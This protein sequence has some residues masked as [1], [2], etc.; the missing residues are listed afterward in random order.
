MNKILYFSLT[1]A[2]LALFSACEKDKF[3][4]DVENESVKKLP[5]NIYQ[6][7]DIAQTF[8]Y[9]DL[10]RLIRV[11]RPSIGNTWYEFSYNEANAPI[12]ILSAFGTDTLVYRGNQVFIFRPNLNPPY[13]NDT[14]IVTLNATGEIEQ[15][16]YNGW[17]YAAP[18]FMN[19][20]YNSNGN[21]S[22]IT[23]LPSSSGRP[24]TTNFQYSTVPSIFRHVNTPDWFF[25]LYSDL[26]FSNYNF[27]F[28]CNKKGYMFSSTYQI[29]NGE[30][31]NTSYYYTYEV[32]SDGLGY[33][34]KIN[35]RS[36]DGEMMYPKN[37][38][39]IFAK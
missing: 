38:Q 18:Y 6:N 11:N 14:T 34:W 39:Y 31:V 20:T 21:V 23:Y 24:I 22:T 29:E 9:D 17:Q 25:I 2:A 16:K 12:R 37:I 8:K 32:D 1:I 4:L 13:V 5:E 10:N 15:L 28:Y 3:K 19:L 36:L 33:A 35:Q 26:I 7:G 27:G 30:I